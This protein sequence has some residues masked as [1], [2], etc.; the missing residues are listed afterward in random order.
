[1][2]GFPRVHFSD[3]AHAAA[4]EKGIA[5][6]GMYCLDMCNETGILTV[7]GS[8]FGQA[9]GSHHFRMTNLVA[10]TSAMIDTLDL[11]KKFNTEFH[12]KYS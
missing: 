11:L 8:G 10:P 7:P 9:E 6:D 12:D 4:A 5:T 1:M 2:Y 3:K